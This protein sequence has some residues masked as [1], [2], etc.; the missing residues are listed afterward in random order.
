MI[1]STRCTGVMRDSL[2]SVS[3]GV[4]EVRGARD[5]TSI[6]V[7]HIPSTAVT[8]ISSPEDEQGERSE[9]PT[10]SADTQARTGFR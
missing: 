8:R 4:G 3:R 7:T 10:A 6:F 5:V 1:W 2:T 9:A